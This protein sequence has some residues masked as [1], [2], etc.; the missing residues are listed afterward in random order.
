MGGPRLPT[1]D[2]ELHRL[3]HARGARAGGACRL[4]RAYARCRLC[5]GAGP[6]TGC[7]SRAAG[8]AAGASIWRDGG[9]NAMRLAVHTSDPDPLSMS[10][11]LQQVLAATAGVMDAP[12]TCATSFPAVATDSRRIEPG[13]LF[14]A[15]RGERHDAHNFVA[16][17]LRG[18]AAV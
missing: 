13:A 5:G 18:G 2:A 1:R 17:A 12:A 6:A 3:E 8:K 7:R 14:V 9:L 10:W 15:L 4:G 11:T 16:E